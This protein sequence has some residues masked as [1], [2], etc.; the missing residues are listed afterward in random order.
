MKKP[1]IKIHKECDGYI[2][3]CEQANMIANSYLYDIT[4]IFHVLNIYYLCQ[5]DENGMYLNRDNIK[6]IFD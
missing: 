4:Y 2:Y 6:P 1:R 3:I 5:K